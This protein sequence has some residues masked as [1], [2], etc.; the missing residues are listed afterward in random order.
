MFKTT[1]PRRKKEDKIEKLKG[2]FV[3]VIND[4]AFAFLFL[5]S[6]A[7]CLGNCVLHCSTIIHPCIC[8]W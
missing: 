7:P 8:P 3:S 6:A 2:K 5:S 4:F 1:E